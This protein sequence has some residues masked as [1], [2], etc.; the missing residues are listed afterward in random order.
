MFTRVYL[1]L[2]MFTRDYLW[3]LAFTYVCYCLLVHVYLCSP[4]FTHVYLCLHLLPMFSHVYSFHLCL[5]LFTRV[6]IWLLVFT[7]VS[8]CL[9]TG[10]LMFTYVYNCFTFLYTYIYWCL[11]KYTYVYNSLLVFTHLYACLLVFIVGFSWVDTGNI[12][13]LMSYDISEII[14]C[15]RVRIKS[16]GHENALITVNINVSRY[17]RSCNCYKF[18]LDLIYHLD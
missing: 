6:Y 5:P 18:I 2:P 1:C 4:T 17:R 8:S 10:L 12:L 15:M 13:A 7:Y 3:L 11:L 14:L 9:P 16:G